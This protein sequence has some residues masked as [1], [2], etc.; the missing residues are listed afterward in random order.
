MDRM[1]P[2][3]G[4]P[5]TQDEMCQAFLAIYP[6]LKTSISFFLST[7]KFTWGQR[8]LGWKINVQ[9]KILYEVNKRLIFDT[10]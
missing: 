2:L 10:I 1:T 9:W 8:Y 3:I 4:G 6:Q 5:T 7:N